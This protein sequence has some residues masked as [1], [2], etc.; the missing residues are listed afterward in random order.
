MNNLR[1]N[2]KTYSTVLFGNFEYSDGGPIRDNYIHVKYPLEW[3]V[4]DVDEK[5]KKMLLPA[6]NIVELEMF[7]NCS[8]IS[9]ACSTSWEKSYLRYW[10]N[11]DFINTAFTAQERAL[12]CTTHIS[13]Q[14]H[15]QKKTLD[16]IF[17]LSEKEYR[18]FFTE[19]SAETYWSYIS[20]EALNTIKI[21]VESRP[22][23]LRTVSKDDDSKVKIIEPDGEF[24]CSNSNA[25]EIGIRP[26][27]WVKF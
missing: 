12:I 23:W 20:K 15:L 27:M 19:H 18:Q 24:S 17:L 1:L 4:L 13:P 3:M 22:W 7:A 14:K 25:D 11:S 5:N 10:L 26:A 8:I 21:S 16:R 9:T 6:K 2:E